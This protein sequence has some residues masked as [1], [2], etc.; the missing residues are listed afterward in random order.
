MKIYKQFF[1]SIPLTALLVTGFFAVGIAQDSTS[2]VKPG[3]K[4]PYI[5]TTSPMGGEMNVDIGNVIEITF[6]NDMDGKSI[7]GTTLLLHATY[8]DTMYKEQS[9]VMPDDQIRDHSII[10]NSEHNWQY[11][12]SGIGGT[13]SYSNKIAVF[14]PDRELKESTLYT[15]T[16]T[17]GVRDLENITLAN[18]Q[19]WS[20]TT[21]GTSNSP[22]FNKPNGRYGMNWTDKNAIYYINKKSIDLGKAGVTS[23]INR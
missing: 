14:T 13:I 19:K 2:I 23:T 9:E 10:K 17:S 7:N 22:Y 18:D 6:S 16:V 5:L 8:A 15:F 4:A 3:T 21:T 1:K 12:T 20:F 11:T